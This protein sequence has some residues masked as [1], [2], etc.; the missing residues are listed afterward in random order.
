[1]SVII[2]FRNFA[3]NKKYI[4]IKLVWQISYIL[5]TV[6]K[7]DQEFFTKFESIS[8]FYNRRNFEICEHSSFCNI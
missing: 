7:Y 1:M 2:I 5:D 8:D 4:Y 6:F 3:K